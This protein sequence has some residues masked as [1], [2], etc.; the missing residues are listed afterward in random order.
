MFC[1]VSRNL[2]SVLVVGV[3]CGCAIDTAAAD[4]SANETRARADALC[5]SYGQGFVAGNAPGQCVKVEERLRIQPNA[6]RGL[7]SSDFPTAFAPFEDGPMRAHVRLNGGF[8]AGGP[9]E[10][11]R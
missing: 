10:P 11:A 8:G 1:A 9:P 3:V 6:R 4:D 7:S 5:A 2:L